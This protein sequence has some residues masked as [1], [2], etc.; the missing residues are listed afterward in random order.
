MESQGIKRPRLRYR[1]CWWAAGLALLA[2]CLCMHAQNQQVGDWPNYGNDPGGMRYSLFTQINRDTVAQAQ[3]RMG[4]SYRRHR[5]WQRRSQAQR[6]R[7]HA[8]PGRWNSLPHHAHSIASLRSIRTTGTQRWAYDPEV[9]R[10]LDYGD[11]LINRGVAAW[12][13]P[14]KSAEAAMQPQ[15]L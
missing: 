14:S 1:A 4:L 5:R 3:G 15:N 12:L 6:I 7:N 13:D 10:S 8:N 2:A 11:G 9:D